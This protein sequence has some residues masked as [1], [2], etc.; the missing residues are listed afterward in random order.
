LIRLNNA[1]IS[2]QRRRNSTGFTGPWFGHHHH[3]LMIGQ[4]LTN[5]TQKIIN[6]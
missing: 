4:G 2:Q 6:G 5:F 1:C 3:A